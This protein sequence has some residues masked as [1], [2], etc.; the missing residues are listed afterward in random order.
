MFGSQIE[1]NNH[2]H[3]IYKELRDKELDVQ[4]QR[5]QQ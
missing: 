2:Y 1:V 3:I 4:Q 5:Q